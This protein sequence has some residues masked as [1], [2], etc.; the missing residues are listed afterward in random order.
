M[1]PWSEQAENEALLASAQTL[2]EALAAPPGPAWYHGVV[3][4]L[5]ALE[6]ALA[7]HIDAAEEV[8]REIDATRPTLVRRVNRHRQEH[9]DLLPQVQALLQSAQGPR[10]GEMPSHNELRRRV[11]ALL[12]AVRHHQAVEDDMVFE[13]ACL[14]IGAGD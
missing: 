8:Y 6:E 12:D 13:S 14:D 9:A 2:E 7:L 4:G 10:N 5:R 1:K 3:T 11:T